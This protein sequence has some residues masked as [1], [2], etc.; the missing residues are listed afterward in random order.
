MDGPEGCAENII[1]PLFCLGIPGEVYQ[2]HAS[3]D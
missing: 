3:D 2:Y 1:C